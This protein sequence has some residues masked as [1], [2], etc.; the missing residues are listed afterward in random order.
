MS[1]RAQLHD[2]IEIVFPDGTPEGHIDRVVKR[3]VAPETQDM[4]ALIAA[5]NKVEAAVSADRVL[6]RDGM[7]ERVVSRVVKKKSH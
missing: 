5:V 1:I 3:V 2:G 6:V 7:E 4:K